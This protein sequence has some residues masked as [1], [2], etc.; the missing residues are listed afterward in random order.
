MST[1][2]YRLSRATEA[3]IIDYLNNRLLDDGWENVYVVKGFLQAYV[4]AKEFGEKKIDIIAVNADETPINKVEIGSLEKYDDIKISI[5]IFARNDGIRLDLKDWIIEEIL[6]QGIDYNQYAIR[7][8]EVSQKQKIGKLKF[9]TIKDKKEL[10]NTENLVQMD[11]F[12][13]IIQCDCR[14]I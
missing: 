2:Y 7:D 14:V 4:K 1:K 10:A 8:G 11:K 13:H 3:S 5:R 12:R 6:L 9:L